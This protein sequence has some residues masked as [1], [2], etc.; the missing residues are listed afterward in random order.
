M[1][2]LIRRLTEWAR[3]RS[4]PRSGAAAQPLPRNGCHHAV[5]TAHGINIVPRHPHATETVR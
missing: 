3:P 1:R 4:A 5:M 2:D